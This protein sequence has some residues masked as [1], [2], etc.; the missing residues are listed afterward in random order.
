M[1]LILDNKS[2]E[3][4]GYTYYYRYKKLFLECEI[5]LLNFKDIIEDTFFKQVKLDEKE[6]NN[7][8]L[9][10]FSNNPNENSNKIISFTEDEKYKISK[11]DLF[12][13]HDK[14][15]EIIELSK[16]KKIIDSYSDY[17]ILQKLTFKNHDTD[18]INA[19]AGYTM[20]SKEWI[21]LFSEFL[22]DK[23][24]LEIGGGVGALCYELENRGIDIV[25]IDNRSWDYYNWKEKEESWSNNILNEDYFQV[26]NSYKDY[27]YIILAYPI[28]GELSYNI[29]KQMRDL[30]SSTKMIYIGPYNNSYLNDDF[31]EKCNIIDTENNFN[32]ISSLYKYW[33]GYPY[34]NS[35]M[36]LIN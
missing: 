9:Y 24:V 19:V 23:K 33:I 5:N 22:K 6:Y 25:S 16:A 10:E 1:E 7:L 8:Y 11:E 35:K 36:L 30:N 17:E 13:I 28:Q 4:I 3:I 14:L 20:L 34:M 12:N 21:D 26:S 18:K 27:D 2:I 31:I 32:E 29:L 15:N